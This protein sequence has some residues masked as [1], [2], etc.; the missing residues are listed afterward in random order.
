MKIKKIKKGIT[1]S[2]VSLSLLFYSPTPAKADLW[3]GDVAVLV[4]ILAN[5]VQQLIRLKQIIGTARDNLSLVRDINRGI[6]EALN[7]IRTIYPDEELSIYKDW[8]NYQSAFKKAEE[9]YGHAVNSKDS[10]VQG[11]LD[12][13]I[14]EAIIM[15]N[16]IAKHSA[17]IDQIGENIKSQSVRSS[18]KGAARLSAEAAGVSLH[19]QNQSLRTQSA[20]LK[21]EA[22]NSAIK[23]KKEKD[24]TRFFL[25]SSKKLKDAMKKYDP[26]YKTPRY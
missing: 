14:V 10:A 9:I 17:K 24:E 18:P 11:H 7:L 16:K 2:V 19:V 3:G 20:L 15:Y 26:K 22:Q 1:I 12:Q 8:D 4:Q 25:E 21:L 13:S 6:N 23:N 5:A